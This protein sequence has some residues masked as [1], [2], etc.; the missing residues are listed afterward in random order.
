MSGEVIDQFYAKGCKDLYGIE[1][2]ERLAS[3]T[4]QA[5]PE[6]PCSSTAGWQETGRALDGRL[7]PV[8]P[9]MMTLT[10]TQ[11]FS[12][13]GF[14]PVVCTNYPRESVRFSALSGRE[15][16]PLIENLRATTAV[17]LLWEPFVGR[18]GRV[19]HD[20]SLVGNNPTRQILNEVRAIWP[21][22][23]IGCLVS[24]GT[25][26]TAS[27][28]T[29]HTNR[30]TTAERSSG[31]SLLWWVNTAV[32]HVSNTDASSHNEAMAQ[33]RAWNALGE[34]PPACFRL[35]PDLQDLE[36]PLNC[37]DAATIAKMRSKT[38]S[39]LADEALTIERA[40]ETLLS[41]SKAPETRSETLE[42]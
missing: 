8:T 40:A 28:A 20:G 3:P 11:A 14:E 17:P 33:L 9:Y 37:S 7:R 10:A 23:Q 15:D 21:G 4:P 18:D 41:F 1:P 38:E 36:L 16:W 27:V 39:Y 12:S 34:T 13:G 26:A 35:T 29:N 25:K 42:A 5:E 6:D 30:V 24:I 31:N 32:Q 19:Y 22:R 2:D